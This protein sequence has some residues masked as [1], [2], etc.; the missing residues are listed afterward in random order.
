MGVGVKRLLK[1]FF[2]SMVIISFSGN[3][4]SGVETKQMEFLKFSP[5][6]RAT[7]MGDSTVSLIGDVDNMFY[8]PAGAFSFNSYDFSLSYA[9][10]FQSL[11]FFNFAGKMRLGNIGDIGVGFV[12]LMYDDLFKVTEENGVLVKTDEKIGLSDYFL[13]VNYSRN[14]LGEKLIGGINL[15][16]ASEEIERSTR[17]V[18]IDTGIVYGI[19]KRISAGLSILNIGIKG[20]PLI[21]KRGANYRLYFGKR[22]K[23]ILSGEIDSIGGKG[24]EGGI[25]VEAE[26]LQMFFIRTGYRIG[27]DEGAFRVGAGI[28]YKLFQIDYS[29]TSYGDL[30][31]VNRVGLKAMIE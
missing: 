2:V 14:L 16:L 15:K 6:V 21:I 3:L 19:S 7:A 10:W 4:F 5:S 8:N 24:I 13:A 9:I 28:K 22:T 26:L 29:F 30:G 20:A 23:F 25:G 17:L 1:L 18:G 12:L 11:N 27:S 31:N